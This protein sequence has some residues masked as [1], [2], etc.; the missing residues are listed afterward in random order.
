[1]STYDDWKTDPDY[2]KS[3][4]QMEAE[5]RI[6]EAESRAERLAATANELLEVLR[7]V[8]DRWPEGP[9]STQ[10][11]QILAVIEKAENAI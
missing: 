11:D 3:H 2:G 4:R 9:S 8:A 6:N 10:Y 1:V 7:V 5:E